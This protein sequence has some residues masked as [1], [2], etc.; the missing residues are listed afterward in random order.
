MK[1]DYSETAQTRREGVF[2]SE[3]HNEIIVVDQGKVEGKAFVVIGL[4]YSL[5]SDYN[6]WD[7][8]YIGE[9]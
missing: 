7:F 4:Q 8:V 2:Y 5:L 6:F 1:L 9:L 3:K